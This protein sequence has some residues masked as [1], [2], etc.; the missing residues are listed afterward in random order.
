MYNRR[1]ALYQIGSILRF[2][3]KQDYKLVICF[4]LMQ[5]W[6]E[7]ASFSLLKC[8]A[9]TS[10]NY[11]NIIPCRFLKSLNWL[12]TLNSE[13]SISFKNVNGIE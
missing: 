3:W 10:P 13:E 11:K 1:N 12:T 5:Y 4:Y 6:G 2:P 9:C 7:N 8:F